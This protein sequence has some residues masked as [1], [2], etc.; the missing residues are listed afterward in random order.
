MDYFTFQLEEISLKLTAAREKARDFLNR[1]GLELDPSLQR[2]YGVYKGGELV[3]SAGYAANVIKCVAVNPD[4]RGE[5]IVNALASQIMTELYQ[6]GMGN[7]FL[8]TKPDNELLFSGVGFSLVEKTPDVL[9]MESNRHA[10]PGYLKELSGHRKSGTTGAIVMNCNPFTLGHQYLIETAA[11][12]CDNL[13]IFTVEEDASAFPFDVR[14][15]LIREGVS[16]LPNVQVIPG[17]AYIISA[18]TFPTYFIKEPQEIAAAHTRLDV[19][20]FG[21]HIAPAMGISL[22]FAGEEPLSPITNLYN[23][24]MLTYL[25]PLG[26]EVRI[27]S[28]KQFDREPISASRVR[29]LIAHQ[30]LTDTQPL[31]PPTTYRYLLS[32]EAQPVLARISAET[33]QT[34]GGTRGSHD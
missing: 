29:G 5:G 32:P 2:L 11:S 28:R 25:P 12:D 20:I 33:A 22:R 7:L 24:A 21:K 19:S 3:G 31:L 9:L 23:Q 10:F 27:L 8:F 26:V 4:Y 17:G 30:R 1:C 6:K 13:I 16:H 15:R 18:A 34:G 14:L